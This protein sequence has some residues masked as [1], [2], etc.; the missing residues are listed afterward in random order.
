[1]KTIR[2]ML[3]AGMCAWFALGLNAKT[4]E[5]VFDRGTLTLEQGTYVLKAN[6]KYDMNDFDQSRYHG[7]AI[8]VQDSSTVVLDLGGR[9]L[10][11]IGQDASDGYAATPAIEVPVGSRLVVTGWGGKMILRGGKGKQAGNGGTTKNPEIH[12]HSSIRVGI[13]GAGGCGGYGSAPAIGSWAG[14]GGAGGPTPTDPGLLSMDAYHYGENDHAPAGQNG[15]ASLGVGTVIILGQIEVVADQ[16]GV[17]AEFVYSSAPAGSNVSDTHKFPSANDCFNS[18]AGGGGGQGGAAILAAYGIGAGAPGAGGGGAG[19]NGGVADNYYSSDMANYPGIGGQ[20]GKSLTQDGANGGTASGEDY[21]WG[22]RAGQCGQCGATGDHGALYFA[23]M[24]QITNSWGTDAYSTTA[25]RCLN[26]EKDPFALLPK[27]IVGK[28]TGATFH[29]GSTAYPYYNGMQL[30]PSLTVEIPEAPTSMSVFKGYWNEA[31]DRIFDE[32]GHLAIQASAHSKFIK[33]ADDNWY[34]STAMTEMKLIPHWSNRVHVITQHMVEDPEQ[35][36]DKRYSGDPY[37]TESWYVTLG[38]QDSIIVS[39]AFCDRHGERLD[40][41]LTT[42]EVQAEPAMRRF[43][44]ATGEP[45]SVVIKLAT[46][47]QVIITHRYDRNEFNY[48][49]DYASVMTEAEFLSLLRNADSYTQPGPQKYGRYVVRPQLNSLRGKYIRDWTPEEVYAIP[50][51]GTTLT[52]VA[53]DTTYYITQDV[54]QGETDCYIEVSKVAKVAYG[55]QV[56]VQVHIVG[57]ACL[58]EYAFTTIHK[59]DTIAA[60]CTADSIFSFAMP[61]DDVQIYMRF[62]KAHYNM[63]SSLSADST[64]RLAILSHHDYR[65]YTDDN[66]YFGFADSLYGGTLQQMVV[67]QGLSFDVITE[68]DSRRVSDSIIRVS[69]PTVLIYREHQECSEEG[70]TNSNYIGGKI[71]KYYSYNIPEAGNMEIQVLW[72]EKVAKQIQFRTTLQASVARIFTDMREDIYDRSHDGGVACHDDVVYFTVSSTLPNFGTENINVF[73]TDAD[74]TQRTEIVTKIPG[75]GS[76]SIYYYFVMPGRDVTLMLQTGKKVAVQ[77]HLPSVQGEDGE[78]QTYYLMAPD[79]AVVGGT[80]TYLIRGGKLKPIRHAVA[81]CDN[82]RTQ[83]TEEQFGWQRR[84]YFGVSND[85]AV[86]TFVAPA[87]D[88]AICN[89]FMLRP[90]MKSGWF[91]LYADEDIVLP[92]FVRAYDVVI[93]MK[94]SLILQ[95]IET[96][97]VVANHPVVCSFSY[98]KYGV[99]ENTEDLR[100][101]LGSDPNSNEV[102][103]VKPAISGCVTETTVSHLQQ[104]L[105]EDKYIYV[106][107][108]DAARHSICFRLGQADEVLRSNSIYMCRDNAFGPIYPT[109]TIMVT[110]DALGGPCY[111]IMG[112][113]VSD[114]YHGIIIREGQKYLR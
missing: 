109:G 1:M 113:R 55:E 101:F 36:G 26:E 67:Y 17:D 58:A 23:R 18:G 103:D 3:L 45:D 49:L 78:E 96:G 50:V 31:G 16:G 27:E 68:L 39:K 11:L 32:Q 5:L 52:A 57:Q 13:G 106:L 35:T 111:N 80:V 64:T 92:D 110:E 104:T 25:S 51:G 30:D 42:E 72:S 105:G 71:R 82:D 89:G 65:F 20:G 33:D 93:D 2:Y 15:E 14:R 79:E 84:T 34:F 12:C 62:A 107:D 10:T 40:T 19:G 54:Q 60:T 28:M 46:D 102:S 48:A 108:Y 61:D 70:Y 112:Q 4:N 53:V 66:D 88:V 59:R 6:T 47:S 91:G 76:D 90:D 29:D 86:G 63:V 74:G 95:E 114:S 44:L 73:Y 56:T 37:Y 9:S 97:V 21:C 81:L 7:A 38:E 43:R 8:R 100:F 85:W 99:S 87:T 22:Q 83:T 24:T 77:N 94:D 69:R 98:E 75:Q 41:L